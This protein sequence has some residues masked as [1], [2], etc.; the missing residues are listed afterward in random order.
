[1]VYSRVSDVSS[2]SSEVDENVSHNVAAQSHHY[3]ERT[4]CGQGHSVHEQ[5]RVGLFTSEKQKLLQ[6]TFMLESRS[7]VS[8]NM[9][10]H[11]HLNWSV[12]GW[13]AIKHFMSHIQTKSSASV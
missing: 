10:G 9:G 3:T 7:K 12:W 13:S 5:L 8:F 6:L 11:A 1:M 4:V 2:S